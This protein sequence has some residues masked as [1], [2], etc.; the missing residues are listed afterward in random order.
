MGALR[1][2]QGILCSSRGNAHTSRALCHGKQ[3]SNMR[4]VLLLV[5]AAVLLVSDLPLGA[6]D[7]AERTDEFSKVSTDGLDD[8]FDVLFEE[9]HSSLEQSQYEGDSMMDDMDELD[10]TQEASFAEKRAAE[11]LQA[12]ILSGSIHP[13]KYDPAAL[14]ISRQKH[15]MQKKKAAKAANAAKKKKAM[16]AFFLGLADQEGKKAK[17]K[18]KAKTKA[19]K[20]AKKKKAAKKAKKKA[21]K[22]MKKSKKKAG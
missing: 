9:A 3:H 19:K 1:K 7:A 11:S 12:E 22:K 13:N 2:G 15:L 18:K 5:F 4:S 8:T 14:I 17:A 20:K 21:K 16:T 6:A 10:A